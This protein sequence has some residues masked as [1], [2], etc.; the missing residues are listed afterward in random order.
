MTKAQQVAA[1][2]RRHAEKQGVVL[3]S[4]EAE[5]TASE[6]VTRALKR[7]AAEDCALA[8]LVEAGA[9]MAPMLRRGMEAAG[10]IS[11]QELA[12]GDWTTALAALHKALGLEV[13]NGQG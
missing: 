6:F 9:A 13:D 11:P 8:D 4:M 2:Y 7:I 3:A 1:K 10:A 5:G 12:T